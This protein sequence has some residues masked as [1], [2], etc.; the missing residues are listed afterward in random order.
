MYCIRT[1]YIH[2][3]SLYNHLLIHNLIKKTFKYVEIKESFL[4][5]IEA[6]AIEIYLDN[7]KFLFA[8]YYNPPK[9]KLS[10]NFFTKLTQ[11]YKNII[12]TLLIF[13]N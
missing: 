12:Q 4:N 7:T 5:E 6:L 11:K 10:Y 13:I 2:K 9:E 1:V 8:T 3:R